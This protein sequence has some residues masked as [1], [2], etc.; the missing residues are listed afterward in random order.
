[1]QTQFSTDCSHINKTNRTRTQ[2]S[3]LLEYSGRHWNSMN[4]LNLIK[5]TV[6]Y[7]I[8]V[9]IYIWL[10]IFNMIKELQSSTCFLL[11]YWS[12]ILF[13]IRYF[14]GGRESS[15]RCN[16]RKHMQIKKMHQQIKKTSS[17][18][19]Q[20]TRCK[21]SQHM[22]I[23]KRAANPHNTFKLRNALQILTTHANQETCCKSSEH[24][25]I[26][27]RAAN[28]HST[29]KLR[30]VLQILTTHAN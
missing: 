6:S 4:I 17:S 19:W 23:K 1:M 29:C 13:R 30:N 14:Y 3:L 15:T 26:K 10:C 18:F 22:Q 2:K 28:P 5:P 25:Q 12:F 16:F 8:H 11:S 20:H 27:K 9:N 24:M 21:S 7:M